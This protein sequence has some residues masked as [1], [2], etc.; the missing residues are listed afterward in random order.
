VSALKRLEGRLVPV[1]NAFGQINGEVA[2]LDQGLSDLGA[3]GT[4]R[5]GLSPIS[6]G[7]GAGSGGGG[8]GIA[9]FSGRNDRTVPELQAIKNVLQVGLAQ[10][11]TLQ[12]Q[13]LKSKDSTTRASR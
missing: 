11:V 4:G 3:G 6:S 7:S 10:L 8:Q 9:P 13:A 1:L 12:T 2:K 5:V